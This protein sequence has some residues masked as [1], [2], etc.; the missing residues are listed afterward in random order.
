[1]L[2]Y[3]QLYLAKDEIQGLPHPWE[4]YAPH[5]KRP[6]AESSPSS[7]KRCFDAVLREIGTPAHEVLPAVAGSGRQAGETQEARKNHKV[8][9]KSE[10]P[11]KEDKKKVD[12]A[13]N[14]KLPGCKKEGD[15]SHPES[16]DKIADTVRKLAHDNGCDISDLIK[17][18]SEPSPVPG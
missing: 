7:V 11:K 1:M 3:W 17:K 8:I 4:K 16:L 15:I 18:L 10:K 2:S 6:Q 9:F 13:K 12:T 14:S 5:F